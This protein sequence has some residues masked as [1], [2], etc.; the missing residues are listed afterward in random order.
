MVAPPAP[1]PGT[2]PLRPL[3]LGDIVTGV[4]A[5]IR[6]YPGSLYYP[7]LL[8][9]FGCAGVFG[10]CVGLA[11]AEVGP[12]PTSG[13]IP[14]Q[15][16][17]H[18][19]LAAV[20]LLVLLLLLATVASAVAT[21]VSTVVLYHA[22]LGRQLTFRQAWTRSR[23]HLGR[24]LGV[25]LLVTA[26]SLGIL[27]ASALPSVLLFLLAG[28]TAAAYG[29][30]L[31]IPGLVGAVYLGVRLVLVVPV[32]VFEEQRPVAALRRAW[33]LNRGAWW[34][35]L[36]F[37]WVVGLLGE[38]VVRAGMTVLG[39]A[40]S[41]FL[42]S[43]AFDSG[44]AEPTSWPSPAGVTLLVVAVCMVVA[45]LM[46]VRAPLAPL[47]CGLLYLDRRLRLEDLGPR[48]VAATAGPAGTHGL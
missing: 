16:L 6:R 23:A 17:T 25:Q 41:R 4:L 40:V 43:D 12:L 19:T 37:P 28:L 32:L 3:D 38:V 47:T 11:Y 1:K 5:T 7:L 30:L 48:I 45:L 36:G 20:A 42:P 34:R 27:V 15:Q 39:M 2:V 8:V 29:L 22:V 21:T 33:R 13:R 14:D 9:A 44:Q 26:A 31:L 24:V 10:G 46:A 18:L 35:S